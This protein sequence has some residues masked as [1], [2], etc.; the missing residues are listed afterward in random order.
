[1]NEYDEAYSSL[2]NESKGF[3]VFQETRSDSG[4]HPANFLDFECQFAAEQ[5]NAFEPKNILDIGSYRHFLLGLMAHYQ[6]TTIDVRDRKSSVKNEKVITCDA[7]SLDLPDNSF[8]T[9]L[10]MCTLEH[11]GLGR[12]G[13]RIDFD[14]DKK[15]IKEMIRVLKPDGRLIFTTTIHN[16][17]PAIAFNAHRIYDYEMIKDYCSGLKCVA[18]EFYSHQAGNFC[19]IE[20]ITTD[21]KWWDVYC[22]CWRKV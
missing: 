9:V 16:A 20:Q 14:G 18:E 12:Y 8:D 1:M 6:V 3:Y 21:P 2:L 19:S 5:I 17:P 7:I 22:G 11:I 13:D 15:A 4:D 10:S